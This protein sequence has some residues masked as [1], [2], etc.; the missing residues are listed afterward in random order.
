MAG[1]RLVAWDSIELRIRG[2][3][4]VGLAREMIAARGVPLEIQAITFRE[5]SAEV[6]G[7]FRRGIS[8]P[9]RFH[10]RRVETD[11]L[12]VRLPIENL[13]VLGILPVPSLLF[14]IAEGLAKVDGVRLDPERK[15]VILSLDRF[16][17]DFL[18][19]EISSIHLVA[20]GVKLTLGGGGADL[21]DFSG[22]AHGP[23]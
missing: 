22:G 3:K 2:E 11:G 18:D 23:S 4:L 20:G 1:D 17:P 7:S 10:L 15:T 12:A 14:H 13:T 19:V 6:A 21:P 16:L 8:I 5:G 9:F